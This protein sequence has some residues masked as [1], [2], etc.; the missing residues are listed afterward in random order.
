MKERR[1]GK[2]GRRVGCLEK[3]KR[4][5]LSVES[6]SKLD[7]QSALGGWGRCVGRLGHP[8][9]RTNRGKNKKQRQSA[10]Q[11]VSGDITKIVKYED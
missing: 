7:F 1:E 5:S 10:S 9:M 2:G 4:P 8:T 3:K 6:Q 11:P